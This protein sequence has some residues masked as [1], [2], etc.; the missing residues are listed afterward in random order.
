MDNT[1]NSIKAGALV[2]FMIS[3]ILTFTDAPNWAYIPAFGIAMFVTRVVNE[4][5]DSKDR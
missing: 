1:P 3:F 4:E 2:F 5:S